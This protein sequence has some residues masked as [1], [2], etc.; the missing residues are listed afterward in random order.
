MYAFSL[1]VTS[2]LVFPKPQERRLPQQAIIGPIGKLDL[3]DELGLDP[4]DTAPTSQRRLT[5]ERRL[6][7]FEPVHS[8]LHLN[9]SRLVESR[10]HSTRVGQVA[11]IVIIPKQQGAEARSRAPRRGESSDHEFL[12]VAALA[13][14]PAWTAAGQIGRLGSLGYD[15]FEAPP[16]GL[17]AKLSA[18]SRDV[19][20]VMK[21][22][23]AL[24]FEQR[25]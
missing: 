3:C 10:A 16:A 9:Q 12:F 8:T 22:L 17:V 1:N 7:A 6:L 25:V 13:F 15:P 23:V 19:L 4:M 18:F 20:A 2:G 21:M 11:L 5:L 14:L 24:P